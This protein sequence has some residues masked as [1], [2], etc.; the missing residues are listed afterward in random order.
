MIFNVESLARNGITAPPTSSDGTEWR[1]IAT[2][3]RM[4]IA[5]TGLTVQFANGDVR[6]YALADD[7]AN[8][9]W[10]VSQGSLTTD[11]RLKIEAGLAMPEIATLRYA[12]ESDGM[13]TLD[14]RIGQDSVKM[15]LRRADPD[16]FPLLQR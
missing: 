15:R 9:V 1:R 3:S 10:R 13:V 12:I 7:V 2:G 4:P 6:Q 8:H 11:L 16:D 14:G 5:S